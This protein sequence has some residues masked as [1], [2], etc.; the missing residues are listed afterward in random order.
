MADAVR[1]HTKPG[2]G[3]PRSPSPTAALN[4][5]AWQQNYPHGKRPQ[6]PRGRPKSATA[7]SRPL[8]ASRHQ[9][10]ESPRH[11]ATT[12][13]PKADRHGRGSMYIPDPTI[14]LS[15]EE[16][17]ADLF[18]EMKKYLA[19][20]RFLKED[21][22]LFKELQSEIRKPKPILDHSTVHDDPG[23]VVQDVSKLLNV[24]FEMVPLS[25]ERIEWPWNE[26]VSKGRAPIS[27]RISGPVGTTWVG[28]V[29]NESKGAAQRGSRLLRDGTYS[30]RC[31][32]APG[33]SCQIALSLSNERDQRF[34]QDVA[35]RAE[36]LGIGANRTRVLQ[37]V[38]KAESELRDVCDTA[39]RSLEA[40]NNFC[41]ESATSSSCRNHVRNMLRQ[42]MN[43][44]AS[45]AKSLAPVFPSVAEAL[46]LHFRGTCKTLDGIVSH[47][48]DLIKTKDSELMQTKS[49]LA[50]ATSALLEFENEV[51]NFV[52]RSGSPSGAALG[53]QTSN[54]PRESVAAGLGSSLDTFAS[55]GSLPGV[56]PGVSP[57]VRASLAA[58]S[59][60][61]TWP[62]AGTVRSSLADAA[63]QMSGNSSPKVQFSPQF[64]STNGSV[65]SSLADAVNQM[66][67]MSPKVRSSAAFVPSPSG[68]VRSSLADAPQ[69]TLR[70]KKPFV[71]TPRHFVDCGT[72]T[73]MQQTEMQQTAAELR[74]A[75]QEGL[76]A[77]FSNAP[78][79][80]T[81]A[82]SKKTNG[83]RLAR[84]FT[85][86]AQK[87][88]EEKS[89]ATVMRLHHHPTWNTLY[90]LV[91]NADL[92]TI[93]LEEVLET[94][95]VIVEFLLNG[96]CASDKDGT[97]F[98][99]L[100]A[101]KAYYLGIYGT[102]GLAARNI[103]NH[104]THIYQAGEDIRKATAIC[105]I[106]QFLPASVCYHYSTS[107]LYLT[108]LKYA[109]SCQ[110]HANKNAKGARNS[111]GGPAMEMEVV[112]PF[113]DAA[114]YIFCLMAK[115]REAGLGEAG[116]DFGQ[117]EDSVWDD[118]ERQCD[119]DIAGS[120]SKELTRADVLKHILSKRLGT[121]TLS[122]FLQ[123]LAAEHS[124]DDGN[125]MKAVDFNSVLGK[126]GHQISKQT[127]HQAD[128]G[129]TS[130]FLEDLRA[131]LSGSIIP[132]IFIHE[133]NFLEAVLKTWDVYK[134][135]VSE[136]LLEL[137]RLFDDSGD[138]FLQLPEFIQVCRAIDET[139]TDTCIHQMF[140]SASDFEV[141]EAGGAELCE[142]RGI[143]ASVFTHCFQRFYSEEFRVDCNVGTDVCDATLI[144]AINK[145]D[146]EKSMKFMRSG[147][148]D[149]DNAGGKDSIKPASPVAGKL[150]GKS[151]NFRK[152]P[153]EQKKTATNSA[154]LSQIPS[155]HKH[156]AKERTDTG[157]ELDGSCE[158]ADDGAS[159][160]HYAG[161]ARKSVEGQGGTWKIS[162]KEGPCLLVRLRRVIEREKASKLY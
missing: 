87:G 85:K 22:A 147:S 17:N 74:A 67:G 156:G 158:N 62:S 10:P 95:D 21:G 118:M 57:K 25:L 59:F 69:F 160:S 65:R 157:D 51:Q 134:E 100:R 44:I 149:L 159:P 75:V 77:G 96:H 15:P 107:T 3:R 82:W 116:L 90:Q 151:L 56:S 26:Q 5:D 161:Q 68:T 143:S 24:A 8:Y 111:S 139:I 145:R 58:P 88:A 46:E 63:S 76:K 129:G 73:E 146:H 109:Q 31:E 133:D 72:Q 98:E 4:N 64:S 2:K 18:D 19:S 121:T 142:A 138:L 140:E 50:Q 16:I 106:L 28:E 55:Q 102:V 155:Q 12:E 108:S 86:A 128:R 38:G 7:S 104:I 27:F 131:M 20:L 66:T 162:S 122:P 61:Q 132:E 137:F 53:R 117:V 48:E 127:L 49:E 123:H 93:P 35:D 103:M 84:H 89:S 114:R 54:R 115:L 36:Q 144:K 110:E 94:S 125:S 30:A 41:F 32:L 81:G 150:G 37:A 14:G 120:K 39:R 78:K 130:I 92:P 136:A 124:I 47:F 45:V 9:S 99:P 112:L 1:H 34:I 105:C 29:P 101:L 52:Q 83:L 80:T 6:T 154:P 42:H 141:E 148:K 119:T 152:Q 11:A 79:K 40:Q 135:A 33:E 97:V 153:L 126:V 60:G 113:D 71:A 23:D 91:G 13:S 70:A 43:V